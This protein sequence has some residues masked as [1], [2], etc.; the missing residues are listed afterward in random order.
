MRRETCG[1]RPVSLPVSM[2]F[3]AWP[4]L[5]V[6]PIPQASALVAGREDATTRRLPSP[7]SFCMDQDTFA[8]AHGARPVNGGGTPL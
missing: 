1:L 4:M 6:L 5:R 7:A 2:L 3:N 8:L